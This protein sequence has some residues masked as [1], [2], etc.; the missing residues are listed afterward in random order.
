[1]LDSALRLVW[2]RDL[3]VCFP[4][5][6][7]VDFVPAGADIV[8]ATSALTPLS[9]A[10]AAGGFAVLG[11][12]I[13]LVGLGLRLQVRGSGVRPWLVVTEVALLLIGFG[14]TTAVD[15]WFGAIS[16]VYS[17]VY[18]EPSAPAPASLDGSWRSV[19]VAGH[20]METLAVVALAL[21]VTVAAVRRHRR[22]GHD[23]PRRPGSPPDE[24]S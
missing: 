15:L 3:P 9:P 12:S 23:G 20:G 24:T 21:L 1:M 2:T 16:S 14:I 10:I 18:G 6:R 4:G 22:L 5:R 13:V 17:N 8:S 7:C 11:A 19:L